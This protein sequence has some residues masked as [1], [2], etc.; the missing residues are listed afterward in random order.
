MAAD[1]FMDLS[2]LIHDKPLHY[3]DHA[4]YK[5]ESINE[6]KLIGIMSTVMEHGK[7]MLV[8]S[9]WNR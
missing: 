2:E 8:E 4:Q 9:R 7:L 6:F 1:N 5:V 3:V